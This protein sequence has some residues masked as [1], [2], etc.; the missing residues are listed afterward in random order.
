MEG[1]LDEAVLRRTLTSAGGEPGSIFG[2][3][4]KPNLLSSLRG[5]NNAAAHWPWAVLV[6]LDQECECAPDCVIQW[7]PQ[8]AP[9]MRL[10]AV[11]RA[12]ESWILADAERISKFLAVPP[13]RIPQR[14]DELPNPKLSLVNLARGSRKPS[15]R[16]ELVPDPVG[17]RSVGPLYNSRLMSFVDDEV[18][19]WRPT[20]AAQRS[21][22]LAKCLQRISELI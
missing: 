20:E 8:P 4:G 13:N 16:R 6:D 9:L 19:G 15:I 3:K 1:D 11:V 22:S 5:Y 14:P 21:P 7:L 17:G 12:I 2:R 10:R 18:N